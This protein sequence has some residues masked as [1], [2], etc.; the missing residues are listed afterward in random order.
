MIDF[1]DE[2]KWR[3]RLA[4]VT[5]EEGLRTHLAGGVRRAYIGFDPTADSLTVGNLVQI[6][7]LALFQRAGHVPVVIAGGGTGLI[8]DPSGKSAERQLR[9]REEV[10]AN[11]ERQ[12]AIYERV[13]DFSG[14]RGA[15]TANR[16]LLLNNL[17]WLGELSFLDALRDV[18]KHFSVN[19]MIQKDS[20][21]ERLS[22]RE[23]GI[24]YTEFSYMVL[25]AYD[26]LE[27]FRKH[28]VT[29]Q[30]GGSDQ[31]GNIVAGA[32]LIRRCSSCD[33]TSGP[34]AFGLT[35]HLITKSDGTKFGKTES[36]AI[37]LTANAPSESSPNRTSPYAFYQFWLNTAD[38]DVPRFLR[39]F[40]LMA[41]EEIEGLE[42][43]HAADASKREAH[44][45]LARHMTT[46]LHGETETANAE[47]AAKA[48]FSGEIA[49][50]PPGLLD[51]VLAS[52]PSSRRDKGALS[53]GVAVLDLLVE[54]GLAQS[55]REAKEFLQGGSVTLNG[56]K[57]GAEDKATTA[58]LLH[59]SV[60]ALR[61]G[62]KAWH[63]T[64]W[65]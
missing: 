36:G 64:R 51:E 50:L 34:E 59:G 22:G 15:G 10:A 49:S 42:A 27:L 62:K 44:R 31:W 39:T 5:D 14:E 20:V 35:T 11:V 26:F 17:D 65:E 29:V 46:M 60:M 47:A 4:Q 9:T 12:R 19:M 16:A 63:V 48:L 6:V 28:G 24:S 57:V 13:L 1:L 54:T 38:A 45:A 58:D 8:G 30:M 61:R 37:W 40:T 52:A 23:Q 7:T 25:Q 2:L 53:Q 55:R 21:R 41:R 18:G 43:T 33:E 56:R 32:D 3:G